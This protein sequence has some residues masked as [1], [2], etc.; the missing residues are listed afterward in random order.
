MCSI[1]TRAINA[2]LELIHLY[3]LRK[4]SYMYVAVIVSSFRFLG[5][6]HNIVSRVRVGFVFP[7]SKCLECIS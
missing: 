7:R 5:V 2:I 6:D 4:F 1:R 3:I